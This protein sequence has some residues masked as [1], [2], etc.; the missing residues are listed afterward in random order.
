M[1][2]LSPDHNKTTRYLDRFDCVPR[3]AY[4]AELA[5]PGDAFLLERDLPGFVRLTVF[6]NLSADGASHQKM[7]CPHKPH[8]EENAGPEGD[9]SSKC[10]IGRPACP[11]RD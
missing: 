10:A 4:F 3:S 2:Q 6:P 1:V 8:K 9:I 11:I 7:R 5:D